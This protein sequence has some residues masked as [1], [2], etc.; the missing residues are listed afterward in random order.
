MG[1]AVDRNYMKRKMKEL[2]RLNIDKIKSNSDTWVL[3]KN[4]FDRNDE[5][6]IDKLFF[7]CIKN[8]L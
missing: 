3:V 4:K 2:F 8:S 1:K 6:K 5:E 7:S